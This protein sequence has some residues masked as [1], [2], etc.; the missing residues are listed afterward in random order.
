MRIYLSTLTL[1]LFLPLSSVPAGAASL[2][3]SGHD[4]CGTDGWNS[5]LV[6][7]EA[8]HRWFEKR[9]AERLQKASGSLAARR[10]PSV[11]KEGVVAV[12]EDDGFV[13]AA[14]NLF[15]LPQDSV[16]FRKKKGKLRATTISAGINPDFGDRIEDGDWG[17]CPTT[18]APVDDDSKRLELPFRVKFY[19]E[20]HDEVFINSDGNLTFGSPDCASSERG[21]T[22]ALNGPPRILPFFGDLDPAMTSGETGVFVKVRKKNVQIT[23]NG[24]PQFGVNNSNTFQITVFKNGKIN[25]A[26]GEVDSAGSIVGVSPGSGSSVE[27]VDFSEDLPVSPTEL[28]IMELFSLSNVVDRTGVV[29]TFLD[30][31]RDIYDQVIIWT[32]FPA[33]IGGFANATVIK[34]DAEGIGLGQFDFSAQVGSDGVVEGLVQMGELARYPDNPNVSFLGTNSTMDIIGQ[35]VG[36]RWLARTRVRLDG[37]SSEEILG[38]DLAHWSFFMDTDESDMEG[39]DIMDLGGSTFETVG[40]TSRFSALD[41]YLMGLIPPEE[42]GPQFFVRDP[43]S[44]RQPQSN[45]ELGHRFTGTRVDFSVDDIIAEEG[46]RLPAAGEAPNSFKMAFVLVAADG[47]P[48]RGESI[49]KLR[50]FANEWVRYFE[51][52]TD[53]NGK[54]SVKLKKRK[55]K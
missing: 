36:H 46:V 44:T 27:F 2:P 9:A 17:D 3:A 8:I 52:G 32:D 47:Q 19:G 41:Q 11:R 53:G 40:A 28:A 37:V 38:R 23:W 5:T 49:E 25:V 6:E 24:V 43:A 18:I 48:A 33:T 51:A 26:F 13:V 20:K 30:H 4:W 39:N 50:R 12:I 15:D 14:R 7:G 22:R 21:L 55:K 34:N 1:L 16:G 54:V 42:V 45:P 35:E 29:K 31:F 10:A